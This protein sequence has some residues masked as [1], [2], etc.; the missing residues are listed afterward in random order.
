VKT[1]REVVQE[2][3]AAYNQKDTRAAAELYHEDAMNFQVALGAPSVG[4]HTT[5]TT[6]SPFSA[7]SPIISPMLKTCLRMG[8]GRCW[9]GLGV[10]LGG[11]SSL[12]WPQTA[13]HS[14]YVA[15]GSS[16][17]LA[18]RSASNVDISTRPPGLLNWASHS[19]EDD[20][21]L[22]TLL[23]RRRL[24]GS[25]I[26]PP[27]LGHLTLVPSPLLG[28]RCTHHLARERLVRA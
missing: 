13:G 25:S 23:L 12:G 21:L 26:K 11:E 10:A 7:L 3:V 8:S 24:L 9:S 27:K 6:C 28:G 14:R 5:W 22:I 18:A 2:W 19:R 16:T 20:L 1:P 15:A 17:L 4:R